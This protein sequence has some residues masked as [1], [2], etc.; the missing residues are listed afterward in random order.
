M[1]G[2][3]QGDR[4]RAGDLTSGHRWD[5]R[6]RTNH[7]QRA[8]RLVRGRHPGMRRRRPARQAAAAGWRLRPDRR[9]GARAI[10][11]AGNHRG[12]HPRAGR[13]YAGGH[14]G[15]H[16]HEGC[17]PADHPHAGRRYAGGHR[18]NHRYAD[19]PHAGRRY[20][21]WCSADHRLGGHCRGAGRRGNRRYAGCR[22]A[23]HLH[24]GRCRGAGRRGNRRYAGCRSADHLLGG[25]CRGA[26]RR[27]NR[28][29]AGCRSA[30]HLHAGHLHAG[31]RY[32][33]DRRGSRPCA[34]RPRGDWP[35]EGHRYA[36]HRPGNCPPAGCRW[37]GGHERGGHERGGHERGGHERG[38]RCSRRRS[39]VTL[40]GRPGRCR[41]GTT[42]ACSPVHHPTGRSGP[43]GCRPSCFHPGCHSGLRLGPGPVRCLNAGAADWAHRCFRRRRTGRCLHHWR[44]PDRHSRRDPGLHRCWNGPDR[45]RHPH[46]GRHPPN[47]SGPAPRH[48]YG[49]GRPDPARLPRCCSTLPDGHS[50]F[51]T[52]WLYTAPGCTRGLGSLNRSRRNP[53]PHTRRPHTRPGRS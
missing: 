32:G 3:Q 6:R 8:G 16:R 44:V 27:G 28:R 40:P 35:H 49:P 26:G 19:R 4:H 34:G 51:C 22:S 11:R 2:R 13:R 45:G 7:G 5:D 21:G 46:R 10:P 30:D 36:G 1:S 25:R 48:H 47:G 24:G 31:H 50:W 12:G 42:L 20:G 29:Y 17:C 9:T 53:G 38:G 41:C 23:D 15:N 43:G 18:G 37:R 14:R 33:G 52:G 39:R